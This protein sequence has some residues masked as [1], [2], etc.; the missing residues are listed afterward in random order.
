YGA[1]EPA[2]FGRSLPVAGVAGDQ[3]AALIGQACFRAGMAKS[4]YG[5]GCFLLLHTGEV[6]IP[7]VKGLLTTP[8]YRIRGRPAYALDGAIFA[9]GAGVKWLRDGLKVIGSAAETASL[10]ASVRD[11]HGV[12]L[13]PAF[14]GLG[15]P[16]WE[17][18][19]RATISGLT[20]DATAA[21][22]ARA[23]LESV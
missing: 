9:A 6:A 20:L 10:A 19:A 5:T 1:S 13:V 4:T 2:L 16:H 22:L 7:S 23:A 11:E 3:Q 17:P 14:V 21:H 12:Y 15:A 18:N 8:A